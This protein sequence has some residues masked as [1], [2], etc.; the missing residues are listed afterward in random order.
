M[1]RDRLDERRVQK[2]LRPDV[3]AERAELSKQLGLSFTGERQA[4]ASYL[5]ARR[6]TIRDL[7]NHALQPLTVLVRVFPILFA[8]AAYSCAPPRVCDETR[9]DVRSSDGGIWRCARAEDCPRRANSVVCET[10]AL[11]EVECVNC[12]ANTC[13]RHI[14]VLCRF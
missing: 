6:T 13:L 4:I 12:E 9:E 10:D 3:L 5:P 1:L 7:L 14:P 2:R 11:P 8:L